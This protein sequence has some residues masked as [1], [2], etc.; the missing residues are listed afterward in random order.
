MDILNKVKNDRETEKQLGWE[1]TFAEYLDLVKENPTIAQT[2]H[3]RV[4]NMI[5]NAGV[6]EKDNHKMYQF[7]GTAIFG[8]ESAIESLVEEYFHPAARR[9]DVRKRILLL[10]GRQ[11]REIHDCQLAETRPGAIFAYR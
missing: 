9:L 8:L 6:K 3:S 4:Y 7:F 10:M 11:W 1:G 5:K 2:A